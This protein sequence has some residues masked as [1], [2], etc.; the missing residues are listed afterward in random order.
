M[1]LAF[2]GLHQ[3][4]ASMLDHLNRTPLPQREALRVAFGLSTGLPPDRFFVV[5][6]C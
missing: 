2:A 3:L 1:E 5:W 4:C 6:R